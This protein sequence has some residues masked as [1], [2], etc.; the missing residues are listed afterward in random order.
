M[1]D[2]AGIDLEQGLSAVRAALS[3]RS[4]PEGRI[5]ID[6]ET[7]EQDLAKLVLGLMEFIRQLMELQAIRRCEAGSLSTEE[8]DQLGMAL[9]R[10]E[11]AIHEVAGE[12]GLRP[13]ELSL[14]LGPLGR[15]V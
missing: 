2:D 9:L 11:R 5:H 3:S 13:D 15:T 10:A 8:E 1:H 6:P 4:G 7:I 12:F 14:D